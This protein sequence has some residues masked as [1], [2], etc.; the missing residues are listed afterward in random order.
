MHLRIRYRVAG[1]HVHCRVFSGKA[2]NMTHGK[3]GDLVF[4]V[5]EWETV[6]PALELIAEV[7]EDV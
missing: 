1:G 6:K 3:N 2:S 7:I 5:Q 4:D